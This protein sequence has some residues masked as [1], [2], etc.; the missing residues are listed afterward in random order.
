MVQEY[1]KHATMDEC[2]LMTSFFARQVL[3]ASKS[4]I[5]LPIDFNFWTRLAN[6]SARAV[7]LNFAEVRFNYSL[8]FSWLINEG[9]IQCRND[10]SCFFFLFQQRIK[11]ASEH[12]VSTESDQFSFKEKKKAQNSTSC[13]RCV[14]PESHG[15]DT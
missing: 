12:K 3:F 13:N 6:E 5:H 7:G 2:L 14:F 4:R 9:I 11:Q 8:A 1:G 15:K 10:L